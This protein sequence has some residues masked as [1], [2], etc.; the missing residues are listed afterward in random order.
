RV[1]ALVVRAHAWLPRAHRRGPGAALWP[2]YDCLALCQSVFWR[3]AERASALWLFCRV[4]ALAAHA[5]QGY[6]GCGGWN[7]R[8]RCRDDGHGA[9]LVDCGD[10]A[11]CLWAAVVAG[12]AIAAERRPTGCCS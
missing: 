8:G 3:A 11:V 10:G 1:G 5:G 6:V 9:Y 7:C 4:G 12:T 2:G